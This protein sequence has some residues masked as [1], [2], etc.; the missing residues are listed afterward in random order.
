[1]STYRVSFVNMDDPEDVEADKYVLSGKGD[2]WTDFF[3]NNL[4]TVKRFRSS[5][6]KSIE[7]V[8]GSD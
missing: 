7:L 1:M 3:D 5:T 2:E 4:G 8:K 6:I